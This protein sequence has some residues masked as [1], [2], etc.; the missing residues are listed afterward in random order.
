MTATIKEHK[1]GEFFF[2]FNHFSPSFQKMLKDGPLKM[3]SM[4]AIF[5]IHHLSQPLRDTAIT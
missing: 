1:L 3:N 4:E 2:L 5:L